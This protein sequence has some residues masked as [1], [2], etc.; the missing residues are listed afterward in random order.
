[1][2][3]APFLSNKEKHCAITKNPIILSNLTS[4]QEARWLLWLKGHLF[5]NTPLW[6]NQNIPNPI[7]DKMRIYISYIIYIFDSFQ[8]LSQKY[9]NFPAN[10][11]FKY[12]QIRHCIKSNSMET[13]PDITM[14]SALEKQLFNSLFTITRGPIAS[15]YS[16]PVMKNLV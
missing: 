7:V 16:A 6:T 13:F 15:I 10:K 12:F 11:L 9:N 14:E 3:V 1:M 4:W 8:Q 2:N 5:R